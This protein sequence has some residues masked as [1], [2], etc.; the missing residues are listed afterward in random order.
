MPWKT[1]SVMEQRVRFVSAALNK[2]ETFKELCKRFGVSRQT[3][4]KWVRR[5]KRQ[6][7][8]ADLADRSR[9]PH[10]SPRRTSPAR[11]Q[12]VLAVRDQKG[13]GAAKIQDVLRAQGSEL[14]RITIQ[15]ILQRHG[16]IAP[17]QAQ[18]L[19]SKRFAREGCNELAQMDY[20]GEYA[21]SGGSKCYPLTL[22]DDCSRYLL[23]LWPLTS[24][25]GSEAQAVLTEHFREFGVPLALLMDHGTPWCANTNLHGL[26]WFSVWLLK[27]G[28]KLHYS[29]VHHPQTQG[30]V[31]RFHRTLKERTKHRGLPT[32]MSEWR[33]WL[34]ELRHEYNHERPHEALGMKRPAQVYTRQNLRPYQ[35]TPRTWDYGGGELRQIDNKGGFKKYGTWYFVCEALAHEQVR[36]DEFDDQLAVTF[37]HQTIRQIDLQTQRS[38]PVLLSAKYGDGSRGWQEKKVSTMS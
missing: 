31:E 20:K 19:A 37:R 36:I 17:E 10:Q 7:S 8:V 32:T 38:I 18:R 21:L 24:T 25:G 23:G 9:R 6:R 22:L 30:K 3:G 26:T 2:E 28:I 16:R 14:P 12:E 34:V 29:G 35:E 11:E 13:W 15:R 5:Y 1:E 4:Y 33:Q 27:Q